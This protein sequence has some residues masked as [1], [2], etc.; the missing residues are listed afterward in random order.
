MVNS[1]Q[2]NITRERK[3]LIN[4]DLGFRLRTTGPIDYLMSD[5]AMNRWNLGKLTFS[6]TVGILGWKDPLFG[7][8][9]FFEEYMYPFESYGFAGDTYV[10]Y[11]P[12]EGLY[13]VDSPEREKCRINI[14]KNSTRA[15]FTQIPY[16]EKW[17]SKKEIKEDAYLGTLLGSAGIGGLKNL[18]GSSKNRRLRVENRL[19]HGGDLG[20][21]EAI[22][23]P[24]IGMDMEPGYSGT[25]SLVSDF[26]PTIRIRLVNLDRTMAYRFGLEDETT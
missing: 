9:P 12:R 15:R 8:L 26:K 6:E 18:M 20:E 16:T 17:L 2:S 14:D 10:K 13:V 19:W 21:E 7:D 11:I 1:K 4:R 5:G 22:F 23:F 25:C 24:K 3:G